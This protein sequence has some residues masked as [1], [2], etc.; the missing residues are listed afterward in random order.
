M[1]WFRSLNPKVLILYNPYTSVVSFKGILLIY[2][3]SIW[4]I[5]IPPRVQIFLLLLSKNK[6]LTGNNLAKRRHVDDLCGFYYLD[7]SSTNFTL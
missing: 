5:C 7:V 1:Q 4:K 2:T 3:L 6:L